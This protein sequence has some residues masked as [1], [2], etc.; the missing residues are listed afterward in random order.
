M[1]KKKR[2]KLQ[3]ELDFFYIKNNVKMRTY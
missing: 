3:L 1:V 2:K